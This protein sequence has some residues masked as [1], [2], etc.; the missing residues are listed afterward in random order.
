MFFLKI[1]R[2]KLPRLVVETFIGSLYHGAF[3][4]N[5]CVFVHIPK[6]AGS[7]VS[8]SLF[9]FQVSHR[10]AIEYQLDDPL[11]F[12]EYYKFSFVRNPWDR[13]V[14]AYFFLKQGGMDVRDKAWADENLSDIDS[15]DQFVREW[16][17]SENIMKKNHFIPQYLYLN[18]GI[19]GS[20]T[21][22]VDYVG[23][24]E[25]MDASF[26]HVSKKIESEFELVT[27]NSSEHKEYREYY[28]EET[29]M[30]VRD[31]YAFDVELFGYKF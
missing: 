20:R 8:L 6:A 7:S 18:N 16:V 23:R 25:D 1:L 29:K 15:F 24:T 28:T 21:I 2:R 9:G 5:E 30:I 19:P 4:S 31:I 14:S 27:R 13:L 11:K 17:N 10:S 12:T 3:D 26:A 22:L